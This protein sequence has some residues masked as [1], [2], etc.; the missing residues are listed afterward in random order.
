MVLDR[1]GLNGLSKIV[2][3][4][5]IG[6]WS[7]TMVKLFP[8]NS[9]ALMVVAGIGLSGM[10]SAAEAQDRLPWQQSNGNQ[11][12]RAGEYQPQPNV[13]YYPPTNAKPYQ[14]A[15][16]GSPPNPY[17]ARG[18]VDRYDYGQRGEA[19]APPR[20]PAAAPRDS[21]PPP[22]YVKPYRPP[23]QPMYRRQYGSNQQYGSNYD[24]GGRD[25][26]DRRYEE[27]PVNMPSNGGG[28]YSE[29]EVV[30]A[31]H[32]FFGSLSRGLAKAIQWAFKK[33]GRPNGYI[34]GE[35]AGGAFVAGLRYGEGKLFTKNYGVRRVFWQGP[36][37]GYDFGGDGN[38]TIT[39][40]YNLRSPH[41]I[42]RRFAGVQGSA[43]LVGGASVQLLK[44]NDVTLAPIRTGVGLR[45]GANIGYL[46]FTRRPTWNPF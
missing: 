34:L 40:V 43:Y 38:R 5:G 23:A 24:N 42:F 15:Q 28:T 2:V 41:G 44:G 32:R 39:L 16:G 3:S 17:G 29:N 33:S 45:L 30:D 12:A 20:P 27:T 6:S 8:L 26:R 25:A 13:R 9:M 37:I 18:S 31:G 4:A 46:K 14:Q 22:G 21:A 7:V 11:Y 36:S 35:D 19:Y 10:M 1:I